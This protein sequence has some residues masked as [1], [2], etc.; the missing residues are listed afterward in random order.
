M[1]KIASKFLFKSLRCKLSYQLPIFISSR[2]GAKKMKKR[3]T[4][5]YDFLRGGWSFLCVYADSLKEAEE[6]F[7][8]QITEFVD[9][10]KIEC[11]GKVITKKL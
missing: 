10:T 7:Y 11:E 5:V 8:R 4:F 2:M 9:I 1:P 6:M 3:F